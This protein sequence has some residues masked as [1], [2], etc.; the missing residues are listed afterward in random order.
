MNNDQP[1]HVVFKV[2]IDIKISEL[3][4]KIAQTRELNIEIPMLKTELVVF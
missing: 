3:I 4:A 1:M 2:D